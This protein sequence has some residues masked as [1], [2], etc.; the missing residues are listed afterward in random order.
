MARILI[1]AA[2]ARARTLLAGH[3]AS[4]GHEALEAENGVAA[5]LLLR[6]QQP[7]LV[8]VDQQVPMGGA[9]T[10]RLL[11]LHPVCQRLPI[12]LL[13][14]GRQVDPELLA[15]GRRA[16]IHLFVA[17][18]CTAA[19]LEDKI[20]EGL[21]QRLERLSINLMREEI[22]QL[23]ELPVL[24]SNHRKMLALLA[25]ENNQ[26]EV[27]E[28]IRTIELDQGLTT[29]V[30]RVCHSAYYGFR[31]NTL[32][33]AVTFLG[34]DKIRRIVQAS[35]IF[36]LFGADREQAPDGFS[37]LELWKHSV[38]CGLVMEA[39]GRKVRGR[40]HFIAGMLHDVGKVILYLRFHD[41]FIEVARIAREE[42]RT[43]LSAEQD[44]VGVTHTDVGHELA[45]RW[46]LPH[47][48]TTAIA[49]HHTPS[50]ALQHQRLA[51]LVHLSDILCRTMQLGHPGD[52]QSIPLDP[53]AQPLARYVF[54]AEAQR[55][56]I[57]AEVES[58]VSQGRGSA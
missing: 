24:L 36:D 11:R 54:A 58:I 33:S 3:L 48:I 25:R 27:P 21:R 39:S 53:G 16:Q 56:E 31:G 8:L 46:D 15:E 32:E 35:I 1:V 45:R 50:A 52:R 23:S 6:R 22:G 49:F 29:E 47:T 26:V 12:L 34:L 20:Q 17:K 55:A 19:V 4:Q 44:L 42:Q 2:S 9:K 14:D 18:P 30:L 10:A 57:E 13:V 37:I 5:A 38:G 41:Y 51:A 7:D 43:F 40:D 28:L